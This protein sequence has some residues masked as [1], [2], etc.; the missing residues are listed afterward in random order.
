MNLNVQVEPLVSIVTPFF[1][2]EEYLADCIESV[3][4]QT[5]L[6]WEYILVN[7]CSNDRSVEIALHYAEKDERIILVYN[8]QFLTQV[9]NYNHALRQINHESKYCKMVQADDMI[10][11]ECISKMVTVAEEDPSVGIVSAYRI[12]G[13]QVRNVGLRYPD[14][15]YEGKNVCRSQIIHGGHYIGTPTSVLTRSEIVRSRN[16]FYREDIYF[17]DTLV[18]YEIL[19]SW[20]FGF[21]HQIESWSRKDNDSI[22][23]KLYEYDPDYLLSIFITIKEFGRY[24][25]EEEEFKIIYS[26]IKRKY[27]QYLARNL[28]NIRSKDFWNYHEVGSGMVGY[29]IIKAKLFMYL[30]IELAKTILSPVKDIRRIIL[31]NY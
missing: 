26:Q 5:Y 28:L 21:V 13:T 24:Y 11:P 16:P 27:L 2:T 30:C 3:L 29:K 23:S 20:N 18:C 8:D 10:L 19:K 15:I 22:S 17:E 12:Y 14:T 6:N 1:N 9:Q 25:L 4:A 7:N 31:G